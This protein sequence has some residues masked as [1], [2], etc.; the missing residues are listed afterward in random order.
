ME[1]NK[2][3]LYAEDD[4][5]TS[6]LVLDWFKDFLPQVNVELVKDGISLE[7][8][9]KSGPNG[10]KAVLTDNQMP[11]PN[12]IHLIKR[13]A[14]L[15]EFENI[16]FILYCGASYSD[17]KKEGLESGAF[18]YLEKSGDYKPLITLIKN[19]LKID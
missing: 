8:K 19:V 10:F 14:K 9:L 3:L 12:G 17:I 6:S 16:P 15:P 11:G 7:N 13:Y 2:S 1:K 18:A 4:E 5:F